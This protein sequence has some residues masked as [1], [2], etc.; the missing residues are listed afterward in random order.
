MYDICCFD[1][2][3]ALQVFHCVITEGT[4]DTFY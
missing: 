4:N 2:I 1:F 3:A